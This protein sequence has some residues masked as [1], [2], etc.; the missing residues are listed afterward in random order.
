MLN[1]SH[2]NDR[3]EQLRVVQI[4]HVSIK[5]GMSF[6]GSNVSNDSSASPLVRTLV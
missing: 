4:I 6:V 5:T 3:I 2:R 1:V